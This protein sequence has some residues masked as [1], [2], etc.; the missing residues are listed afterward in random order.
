[1][2]VSIRD[3]K[4]RLSEYLRRLEA[5]EVLTVTRRGRPVALLIAPP[6]SGD[7]ALERRLLELRARGILVSVGSKTRN[8]DPPIELR[9]KGP[10]PSQMVLEDRR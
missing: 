6:G 7:E 9:G 4:N 2:E 10:T 3:F 5:G 8:L 1:M